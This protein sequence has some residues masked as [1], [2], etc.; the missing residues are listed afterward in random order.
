MGDGW[1][2]TIALRLGVTYLTQ[3]NLLLMFSAAFDQS[4]V[5]QD[6]IGIPDSNAY[7]FGAGVRKTFS[8]QWNLGVA[9]SL[10]LKD[11]R[12]SIYQTGGFGQLHLLSASLGY[13][14]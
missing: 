3:K 6:K 12:K 7:M 9:Y 8:E 1:Q 14:F 13:Q 2:D 10:S 11:G 4:P 5:P